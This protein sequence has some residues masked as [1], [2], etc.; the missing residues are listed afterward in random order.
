MSVLTSLFLDGWLAEFRP[1]RATDFLAA[2]PDDRA[3]L[4]FDL[5]LWRGALPENVR[6]HRLIYWWRAI[7]AACVNRGWCSHHR[8]RSPEQMTV[9]SRPAKSPI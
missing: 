1:V 3:L 2:D 7:L 9:C 6:R 5:R 8:Q 4:D